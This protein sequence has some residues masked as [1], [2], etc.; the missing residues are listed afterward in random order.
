MSSTL[1]RNFASEIDLSVALPTN[2]TNEQLG[3]IRHSTAHIMAMAVQRLHPNAQVTVGPVI[4]NGFYYDFFF[5]ERQLSD[6]DLKPI[7]K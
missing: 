5:P 7:K 6:S 3:K 2:E 1:R 4:D